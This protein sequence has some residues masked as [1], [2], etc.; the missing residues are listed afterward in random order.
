MTPTNTRKSPTQT[1]TA[2]R[3]YLGIV[4][5]VRVLKEYNDGLIGDIIA[6]TKKKKKKKIIQ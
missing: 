3:E 1:K 5:G 2:R 6:Q 4:Y